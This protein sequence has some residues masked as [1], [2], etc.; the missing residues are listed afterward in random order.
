MQ[1]RTIINNGSKYFINKSNGLRKL[2]YGWLFTPNASF[3]GYATVRPGELLIPKVNIDICPMDEKSLK[4]IAKFTAKESWN[5]GKY[6]ASS[7][8]AAAGSGFKVLKIDGE[9][10]AS[11]C[12]TRY[13]KFSFLGHYFVRPDFRGKGFGKLLWD[14]TLGELV[15]CSSIGLNGVLQ[16]VENYEK[17]G[18]LKTEFHNIRWF[19]SPKKTDTS[20]FNSHTSLRQD[21]PLTRL[22]D[23][24]SSIF[25]TQRAV[26]LSQWLKMPESQT[27][28]AVDE[29]GN[30][31]GYACVSVS[32]DGYKIAP[33]FAD[34]VEIAE[35]L[36]NGVV[37]F[38]G[39]KGNV[40]LDTCENNPAAC[41][42]AQKI[43]LKELFRTLPMWKGGPEPSTDFGRV[44]SITAQEL[45]VS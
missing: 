33:L 8:L 44:Y 7:L 28:S 1:S 21:F 22:V 45:G 20:F 34:S 27:L 19:G 36:Y 42:L 38:V 14:V 6:E 13:S 32:E 17:S 15:D 24:D 29:A 3:H 11:L 10:I 41:A 35:Q 16:Q 43:G 18:F 12:S 25:S 5:P 30:L 23:Y 4:I 37:H 39:N 40:Y 9:P 2:S 31:R 26:F